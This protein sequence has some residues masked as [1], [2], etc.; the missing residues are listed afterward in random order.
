VNQ[1]AP[2]R[3]ARCGRWPAALR[4]LAG[5]RSRGLERETCAVIFE[6]QRSEPG[7]GG[8]DVFFGGLLL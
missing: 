4:G 1:F 7:F 2:T 6:R 5:D 3:C 8:P